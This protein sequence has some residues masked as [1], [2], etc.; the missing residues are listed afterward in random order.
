MS[1]QLLFKVGDMAVYDWDWYRVIK[2]RN[3]F[4]TLM[5]RERKIKDVCVHQSCLNNVDR[6]FLEVARANSSNFPK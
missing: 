1:E 4:C 5:D 6:F 3:G 2:V